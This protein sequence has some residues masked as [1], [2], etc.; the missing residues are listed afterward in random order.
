M[1]EAGSQVPSVQAERGAT[2]VCSGAQLEQQRQLPHLI[3]PQ[4][5]IHAKLH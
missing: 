4:L 1:A 5:N 2:D 3:E